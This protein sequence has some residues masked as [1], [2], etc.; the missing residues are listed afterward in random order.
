MFYAEWVVGGEEGQA[1]REL[2]EGTGESVVG[3]VVLG[4]GEVVAATDGLFA[5]IAFG[6]I[7]VEVYFSE[8]SRGSLET[9]GK[10]RR[11][12]GRLL[13][14]VFE[15]ADHNEGFGLICAFGVDW[16]GELVVKRSDAR[17]N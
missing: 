1:M 16:V 14:V 6:G 10:L 8:E 2:P 3:V 9:M 12:E 11:M 15:L 4:V 17:L 7:G 5:V 13:F